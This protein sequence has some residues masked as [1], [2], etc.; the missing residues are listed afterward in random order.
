MKVF[1]SER[2]RNLSVVGHGDSGKTT[3]VS[4]LLYTSGAVNRLGRVE[5]GTTITDYDEDE[6]ERKITI[7]TALAHCEWKSNKINLLDTPGYRAFILDAKSS[8][9]AAETALVVVDSVSGV[10]VQTE[11]VWDFAAEYGVPRFIVINKLDRDNGSFPRTL[12]AC[13]KAFGREVVPVQ[14]PVGRE[15]DFRG[16]VDLLKNKA[17]VSAWDGKGDTKEEEIPDSLKEEVEARREELIEMIAE[18]DDELMEQFFENGTLSEAEMQKG[19]AKSVKEARIFPVFCTSASHNVGIRSLLESIV[20]LSPSPVD[21]QPLQATKAGAEEVTEVQISPSGPAAAFVFKTLADPFAGRINLLKVYAGSLK[22]DSVVR[23]LSKDID[24]RLGTLQIFQ[25]KSHEAVTEVAAGDICGVLKLKGTKTGDTLG[26]RGF[27]SVFPEVVYSE[28]A[29]SFAVEPAS[30]GD[31]EKIGSAVTKIMEEDPSLRFDRDQQT[32]EFLLSGS[33]QLHI[34]VSVGKLKKRFGVDVILKTPKVPYRETITASAD[35]QGRHKKQTGGH[36]Q[37]GDCK[38]KMEPLPRDAEFEFENKIFGGAIPRTYI[39]AV[40]KG[41]LEAAAKGYLAG[42]PVVNFKVVL[43]DGSYHEVDS[44]EMAFKIA[45]ALAFKKAMEKAR[46][47]LLEPIMD[48]EVYVPEEN[49]GDIMGDLNGRRGR[50]QGMDIKGTTQVVRA[51]VPMAEMLNYQPTL[52]SMTGDRGSYHMQPSHYDVV[53]HN[54]AEKVI[55]QAKK[56]AEEAS[57]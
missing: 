7:N 57:K 45:G 11:V 22:S 46:P 39:P 16:V 3:L 55:E 44:S 2:I 52:T 47:V 20:S 26:E 33:G 54:L 6:I 30:R 10:E 8:M 38:I 36:G 35:V 56:E 28:P 12:E 13:Q 9:T 18:S 50:I 42:F 49:A 32:N 23:N 19:L 1:E 34:E 48:V 43:Y 53:P 4:A 31:E 25:G 24:E 15:K 29:I 17:L 37:F 14:I 5:D 51:Q 27:S 21:R 40:E 41:I